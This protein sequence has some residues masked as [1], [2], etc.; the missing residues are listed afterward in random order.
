MV[1]QV[2]KFGCRHML[3]NAELM[4][5]ES[6]RAH[7]Y[8]NDVLSVK[9]KHRRDYCAVRS[10]VFP[11]WD[12]IE[13]RVVEINEEVEEL[14]TELKKA[15]K[16]ASVVSVKPRVI[17]PTKLGGA[18][19]V[20][21]AAIKELRAEKKPLY[22]RLSQL[23]LVFKETL[24][25]ARNAFK[26]RT[27][28]A[29]TNAKA[30]LN[31]KVLAQML[32]ED[33]PAVWKEVAGL[34]SEARVELKQL[35]HASGLR[36][37]AY[38]AVE[39]SVDKA[40]KTAKG[41]PRFRRFDGGR[42]IGNQ[43]TASL[44]DPITV[45][46][47]L[48]GKN[49]QF[50]LTDVRVARPDSRGNRARWRY[51]TARIRIG[52]NEDRSPIWGEVEVLLHRPI[53]EDAVIRWVYLV[54]RRVGLRTTYSLQLTLQMDKPLIVRAPGKGHALL[55]LQWH[56]HPTGG[57]VVGQ[58]NGSD[59]VLPEAVL[60]G[61]KKAEDLQ[62]YADQHF[63]E[64]RAIFGAWVL[65]VGRQ[66]P[67]WLTD[68][69]KTVAQWRAHGRLANTTNRWLQEDGAAQAFVQP[70]WGQ[71][72]QYREERGLDFFDSWLKTSE[73]FEA[74]G[75]KEEATRMVLWLE[76]WRRKDAHL[77]NWR[78]CQDRK[79]RGRRLDI[80]R[81]WAAK[82]CT[83]FDT[84]E[85]DSL[86]LPVLKKRKKI[87]EPVPEDEQHKTARWQMRAAAPGELKAAIKSAFG[88]DRY[89]ET[90][91]EKKQDTP[92]AAE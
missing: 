60:S 70:L 18:T 39:E 82:F 81:S 67:E 47:A 24:E 64:T 27:A 6:F 90:K 85:V 57:I 31:E 59:L 33:W 45:K 66:A 61:M 50:Q 30:L 78:G 26:E 79:S 84:I 71:W 88:P 87:G 41:D 91:D 21:E 86:D 2:M 48:S 22:E 54:P 17:Q 3:T 28:G 80:Y 49:Q 37:G 8:Y 40:L 77:V 83:Q 44:K 56:Q 52:S 73:W 14:R 55:S 62:G 63:N 20:V 5:E 38:V 53:P 74:M 69:V 51:A 36:H 89:S 76:W 7:R 10:N 13:A 15:R 68:E 11:E 35:R 65:A 23:R 9:L 43:I 16:K 58:L 42:K 92:Q 75:V 29:Q 4:C 72:K 25:P 19:K 1:V 32:E 34:E 46:D 12:K